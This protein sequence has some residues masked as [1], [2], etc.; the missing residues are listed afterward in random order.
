MSSENNHRASSIPRQGWSS[1]PGVGGPPVLGGDPGRAGHSVLQ[2]GGQP[3]A[4][5]FLDQVR[6]EDLLADQKS[7]SEQEQL[8]KQVTIR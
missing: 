4:F 5:S 8:K 6:T 7:Q 1:P 3:V 2:G